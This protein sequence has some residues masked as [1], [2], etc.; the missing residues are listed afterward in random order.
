MP[1]FRNRPF[2]AT[3]LS[4]SC[5]PERSRV[6]LRFDGLLVDNP[7]DKGRLLSPERSANATSGWSG[8]W[9]TTMAHCRSVRLRIPMTNREDRSKERPVA[10]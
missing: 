7:Y 4:S 3:I 8:W 9:Q 10:G 6:D 2:L 5:H 1:R